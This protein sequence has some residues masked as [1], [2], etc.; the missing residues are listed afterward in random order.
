MTDTPKYFA[1]GGG[2]Q[3]NAVLALAATG[4]VKYNAFVFSNVGKDSENPATLEYI[5]Q[6]SKPFAA[7]HN[8]QF[9]EIAKKYTLVEGIDRYKKTVLLPMYLESG[10]PGNRACTIEW[11][12]RLIDRWIKHQ[13]HKVATVGLGIS[14]DEI[15]R[16]R[17]TEPIMSEDNLLKSLEYPLIDLNLS[18]KDCASIIQAAGLPPAPKSA[19]YF[20]PFQRTVSWINLHTNHPDLFAKAAEIERLMQER[21][22]ALGKDLVWLHKSRTPIT[23]VVTQQTNFFDVIDNCES[24]YCMT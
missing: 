23:Q 6:Y 2:I 10:A 18:R 9:V 16:A 19:C 22:T 7:R 21:R 3:S 13:G 15:H 11:K 17:T 24:G 1:F 12:I 5:E 8:I 4:Q 14:T 20:C